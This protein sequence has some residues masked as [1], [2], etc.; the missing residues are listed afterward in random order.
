MATSK[1]SRL[2]QDTFLSD[3][4][5]HYTYAPAKEDLNDLM[6]AISASNDGVRLTLEG[7]NRVANGMSKG[8]FRLSD[9]NEKLAISQFYRTGDSALDTLVRGMSYHADHK[10][11]GK[12]I[13]AKDS[14]KVHSVELTHN[15][16]NE[17]LQFAHKIGAT[18][19]KDFSLV[20][21]LSN[22][23]NFALKTAQVCNKLDRLPFADMAL[24]EFQFAVMAASIITAVVERKPDIAATLMNEFLELCKLDP[25]RA[26]RHFDVVASHDMNVSITDEQVNQLASLISSNN[27][28]VFTET[29]DLVDQV[30]FA[31]ERQDNPVLND[32][33]LI[34]MNPNISTDQ[35]SVAN[36]GKPENRTEYRDK[37]S[38]VSSDEVNFLDKVY[39]IIGGKPIVDTIRKNAESTNFSGKFSFDISALH[40]RYIQL[41]DEIQHE[42][43]KSSRPQPAF[44]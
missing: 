40:E 44:K 6:A 28:D 25:A 1:I 12:P 15:P 36:L 30:I 14:L 26:K 42:Q 27:S 13:K 22:K 34:Q 20:E 39:E 16:L 5:S 21:S 35:L 33:Y 8:L 19:K 37:L 3:K 9:S 11:D 24:R 23:Y 2:L 7:F 4:N 41:Q 31:F 32:H 43:L 17:F 18:D 38:S 29:L 10:L